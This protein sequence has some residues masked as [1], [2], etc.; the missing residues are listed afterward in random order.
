MRLQA[1]HLPSL[2]LSP[3]L[4]ARLLKIFLQVSKHHPPSCPLPKILCLSVLQPPL[5]D[6]CDRAPP[7]GSAFQMYFLHG[8]A[9]RSR[10]CIYTVV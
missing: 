8:W 3:H 2:G 1:D 7:E 10:V 9:A 6:K 5:Q 4:S